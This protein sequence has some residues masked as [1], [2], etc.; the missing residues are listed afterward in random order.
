MHN[1]ISSRDEVV[2]FS[3]LTQSEV[4]YG[5]ICNREQKQ[6]NVV[7]RGTAYSENW[8]LNIYGMTGQPNPI[9]EDYPGR[10]DIL[11]LHMGFSLYMQQKRKDTGL[12]KIQE[13]FDKVDA[14]GREMA[15]DGDY[16][17]SITGHSVGGAL[18]TLLGFYAASSEQFAR[19][20]EVQVFTFAAPRIG[21]SSFVYAYQHLEKTGKIQY[22]RFTCANDLT[23]SACFCNFDGFLPWKWK[24]YQHVGTRVQLHDVCRIKKWSLQKQLV[25]N[26]TLNKGRPSRIKL[27]LVNTV[28]SNLN[29]FAG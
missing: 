5:I 9:K 22:L 2:W 8:F 1:L 25:A 14:I 29:F 26:Y 16:K 18:S 27:M 11:D 20:K 23:P 7:F 17:L 12:S 10:K 24:Y 6:V 15:P 13:I 19:V 4:I 3:D 21:S 28:L